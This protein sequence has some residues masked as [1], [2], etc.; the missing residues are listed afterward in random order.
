MIQLGFLGGF[1]A[2]QDDRHRPELT[3]R[4]RA[5]A[6][7]A[8][9]SGEM[10]ISRDRVLAFL[11]P[12]FDTD[13]ARN[14]LKQVVFTLRTLLRPDIFVPHGTMLILDPAVVTIDVRAFD[15]CFDAGQFTDTVKCYAGPLLEGFHLG[16]LPAFDEWLERTRARVERRYT[17]ALERLA[18]QALSGGDSLGAVELF[19]RLTERDPLRADYALGVMR[20][21]LD[22]GEPVSAL[23]ASRTHERAVRRELQVDAD[24]RVTLLAD[25]IRR[26]L[27]PESNRAVAPPTRAAGA[28]TVT[29]AGPAVTVSRSRMLISAASRHS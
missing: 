9:A 2:T 25:R 13:H 22:L 28:P 7:L 1:A 5:I 14:N 3:A 10:G 16:G 29:D 17:I 15:R 6:V 27:T 4:R 24:P 18:Q 8:L 26:S 11:W 20:S 23:D 19:R 12:E 21:L